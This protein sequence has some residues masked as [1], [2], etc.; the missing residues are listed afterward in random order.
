MHPVDL[1]RRGGLDRLAPV[2]FH[3]GHQGAPLEGLRRYPPGV[4]EWDGMEWNGE[5]DG[6]PRRRLG[7][8]VDGLAISHLGRRPEHQ[9]PLD[10]IAQLADVPWPRAAAKLLDRL[11]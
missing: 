8:P 2:R 11:R 10:V 7:Q 6:I 4:L 9:A 3:Q 5:I 1:R